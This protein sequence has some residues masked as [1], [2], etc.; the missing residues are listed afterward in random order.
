M[1]KIAFVTFLFLFTMLNAFA[2]RVPATIVTETGE[3][4]RATIDVAGTENNFRSLQETVDYYD[5]NG[6]KHSLKAEQVKEITILNNADTVKLVSI[7]Y[8]YTG[9]QNANGAD[10]GNILVQQLVDGKVSVYKFWYTES[11]G[12]F[13]PA[14]TE[15]YL[16][17]KEGSE[18]YY[19]P[20]YL[21][22]RKDMAGYLCDCPT[23][24]D[25][26]ENGQFKRKQLP[27]LIAEYNETCG[28]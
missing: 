18:E 22:F 27:L 14:V 20:P 1:K 6:T 5:V 12:Q 17:R 16:L 21:S 28:Y 11:G 9:L 24:I 19:E 8:K 13:A 3:I 15:K 7:P 23:L 2:A 26:I 10:P 4:V 25:K